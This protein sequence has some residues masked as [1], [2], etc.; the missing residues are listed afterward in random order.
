MLGE[1]W[2]EGAESQWS[3]TNM[4]HSHR[5]RTLEWEKKKK[6]KGK[7]GKRWTDFYSQ[8]IDVQLIYFC[9]KTSAILNVILGIFQFDLVNVFACIIKKSTCANFELGLSVF[10][11]S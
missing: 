9:V 3:F 10:A 2:L 5:F 8:L 7:W 11:T 6:K 1:I 4:T